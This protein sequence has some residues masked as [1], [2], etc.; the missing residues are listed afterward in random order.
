MDAAVGVARSQENADSSEA[1]DY[2]ALCS[3]GVDFC[4]AVDSTWIALKFPRMRQERA[5]FGRIYF[6]NLTYGLAPP[7]E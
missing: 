3:S 4:C 2:G 7:P 6:F 1:Y 5:R